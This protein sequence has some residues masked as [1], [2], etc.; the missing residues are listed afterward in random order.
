MIYLGRG[1]SSKVY[2]ICINGEWVAVKRFNDEQK[3]H[4]EKFNMTRLLSIKHF[5]V[6]S[7]A[8]P[9]KIINHTI[10]TFSLLYELCPGKTLQDWKCD[11]LKTEACMLNRYQIIN[12]LLDVAKTVLDVLHI[13]HANKLYHN[14]VKADNIMICEENK[15]TPKLIDYGQMIDLSESKEEYTTKEC[16]Y[17][18]ND[19]QGLHRS[20][21]LKH[22]SKEYDNFLNM[23]PYVESYSKPPFTTSQL[24]EYLEHNRIKIIA[25]YSNSPRRSMIYAHLIN[26]N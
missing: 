21:Y 22:S 24:L 3:Y 16:Y 7:I 14:D 17:I 15:T 23:I 20:L 2:K 25:D 1:V 5:P 8:K 6:Q 9:I 13:M 10:T 18:N 4:Q 26:P 12:I 19:L 11:I